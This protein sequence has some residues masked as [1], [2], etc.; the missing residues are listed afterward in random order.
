VPPGKL[1]IIE[2]IVPEL[3]AAPWETT[4]GSK[5]FAISFNCGGRRGAPSIALHTTDA[6]D[7]PQRHLATLINWTYPQ[8]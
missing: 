3:I 4:Q 1:L 8:R 5:K 6:T 7:V 2:R